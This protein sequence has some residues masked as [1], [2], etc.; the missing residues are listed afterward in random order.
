M[1]S[2]SYDKFPE[3][4]VSGYANHAAQGWPAVVKKVRERLPP[5]E[6]TV[7]VI[8]CYP[9]VRLEELAERFFPGL[10]ATLVLNVETARR[11][12][13][14]LQSL[15]A[16]NLTNDRVFGVISCHQLTDFFDEAKLTAL[17]ERVDAISTGLVI[18]YGSGAALV[19]DGDMLIYADMPRWEIQQRMRRGEL[20][21]WGVDN[22]HEDMLRRYKRAYFIEWR[23]FDRH[24][25]PLL[26]RTDFLL[27]T[28]LANQPAIVSGYAFRAG[29]EQL[30]TRPFRVVPFFDPGVW[31]GQ[32]MKR[33]FDLDPS[34]PNYAW[35]FDCVPEEN[36][37]F[38]RFG[39]VR[40]EIPAQD[41]VLLYPRPLL[42]EN[43]HARFG[44]EFP[45]RFDMLDTIG[46]KNLSLQVHP[47]TDYIQQ[48]FGMHY[49]QDES[50]YILDAEPDAVVYLG[51]QTGTQPVQMVDALRRAARGEKAFDD[52][53]FVNP[54]PAHK[55]D[56][57][58]IPAGT[59]HGAGAGTMVLEISA[60]PYIFTFKLWDWGRLGM[61]GLPRPVHL[62]HG[63][64]VI[65]WSRDTDW[66]HCHLVNQAEPRAGGDG[67]REERTGLHE[68]EFIETR[69][70]WFDKPVLHHTHGTVNVL[71]LVEGAEALVES[72][73]GM[74]EPFVVH[75]AETFIVPAATGAYRISP[76]GKGIGQ[77]LATIK[78]WVRG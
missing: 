37:L 63:A 70:H 77:Q 26:K 44:A 24:K 11:D 67:W 6:K 40:T 25:T 31:G 1:S 42:G 47:V 45:I 2:A 22:Q 12:E 65:D 48:Q 19:H 9:G 20:G 76:F 51:V 43:V 23:V 34:M 62:E 10:N 49:T 30:T 16:Y 50:Y 68:R 58:L 15:L 74:F 78:A 29:L 21:N 55:H 75:Y 54:I 72:P 18:V 27:D 56:H 39:T 57:F 71:N 46:G 4:A 69:R 3:V 7:V 33:T 41:L 53:R 5:A 32:W 38:L 59:V 73:N 14:E 60:T 52:A 66:V 28:T 17:R 64:Q 61:D 13:R 36:S 35:C 8:D